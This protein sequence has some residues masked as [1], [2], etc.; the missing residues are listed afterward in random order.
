MVND[1][2]Q[3]MHVILVDKELVESEVVVVIDVGMTVVGVVEVLE[4]VYHKFV[5]A[6]LE[7]SRAVGAFWAGQGR[8]G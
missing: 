4:Y 1:N 8:R 3:E 5:L 7:F 6:R 2:K